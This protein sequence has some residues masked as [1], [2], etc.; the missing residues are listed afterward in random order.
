M[1]VFATAAAAGLA[2]SAYFRVDRLAEAKIEETGAFSQSAYRQYKL[3]SVKDETPDTKL[4]TFRLPEEEMELNFTTP[5]CITLRFVDDDRNEVVRPYTPLNLE[6]DKGSFDIL[7]KAYPN[8]KMG[9]HLHNMKVGN[10]IDVQG[11][12]R[13]MD[14]KPGQY[15][16]VGMLAGGTGVTPMY[17]VA[18]NFLAKPS[19][20]TK[21]SLVCCN[22]SKH[23]MLLVD[24]IG[25]LVKE[26]PGRFD[27]SHILVSAPWYWRGY[28]GYL[29]KEI[30][31]R[32]MPNPNNAS[33]AMLLV[34]GPPGFMKAVCG[35]K[36]GRSQG[37][38]EGYLKEMGY[39]ESMVYKF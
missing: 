36:K 27:V 3:I 20:T 22:R 24:R 26:N 35:E 8:S 11:P 16:H 39:T 13:T 28:K 32:T 19:N 7:V 30:I 29:T 9:S 23:D 31:E 38:L 18:Q 12:W 14:I 6:S 21:F 2:A 4:F 34:S 15:E 1:K 5:S 33:N 25:R 10:S 17:Q 37:P